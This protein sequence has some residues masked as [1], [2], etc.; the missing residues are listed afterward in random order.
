MA[1]DVTRFPVKAWERIK[2]RRGKR[3]V[4]CITSG[5]WLRFAE[6]ANPTAAGT[7]VF[8]DV[9]TAGENGD[10]KLCELCIPLEELAQAVQ[11]IEIND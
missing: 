4:S 2:N 3:S 1:R 9:M 8:V 6:Q 7:L 11:N 5:R 10:R